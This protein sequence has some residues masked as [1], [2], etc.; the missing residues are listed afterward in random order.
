MLEDLF[1]IC[2]LKLPQYRFLRAA[3]EISE[4]RGTHAER[5]ERLRS[6]GYVCSTNC[7]R[8]GVQCPAYKTRLERLREAS[9]QNMC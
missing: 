2:I 8:L 7:Q 1:G 9:E 3:H 6:K 5:L 4:N